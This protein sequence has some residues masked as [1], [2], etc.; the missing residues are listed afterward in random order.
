MLTPEGMTASARRHAFGR[1]EAAFEHDHGRAFGHDFGRSFGRSFNARSC[2]RG[3]AFGRSEAAFEHD[4]G[5]A[6]GRPRGHASERP[7][8]PEVM[9]EGMISCLPASLRAPEGIPS[10]VLTVIVKQC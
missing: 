7:K 6:S 1:S 4:H 9:T 8:A 3:H 2:A 5:R 10:G